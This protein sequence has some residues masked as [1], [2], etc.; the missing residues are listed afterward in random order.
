MMKNKI[1]LSLLFGV[2]VASCG[3]S[4]SEN[5]LLVATLYPQYSLASQLA[6]DLIDVE[7]LLPIGVDPH[8]FEPNPSQRVK[9]NQADVVLYTSHDFETWMD[10][11]EETAKGSLIDLSEYVNLVEGIPHDDHGFGFK[12][13][14]GDHDHEEAYDPHYW[15]DPENALLMLTVIYD[16]LLPL[17]PNDELLLTTRKNS[18][19]NAISEIVDAFDS[20]VEDEEELDVVFAGHNAFAYLERYGVHVLTPYPGFSSDVLPTPQSIIDF[21]NLMTDLSTNIL[22][23]SS[24]DNASVV[25]VLLEANPSLETLFLYTIENVSLAQFNAGV[26]FQELLMLNYEAL[27]ES[28]N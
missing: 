5:K 25:D 6:G 21:T 27:S 20:L 15:I 4:P 9:L 13:S 17:L 28:A 12:Y 24:T 16:T 2:T 11:I 8:N 26:T 22:Y 1:L 19:E 3:N 14:A 10:A 7:F 18:I 23:V